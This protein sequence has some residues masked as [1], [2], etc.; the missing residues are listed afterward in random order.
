MDEFDKGIG[1][2]EAAGA[3]VDIVFVRHPLL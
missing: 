2:G 3:L 1:A